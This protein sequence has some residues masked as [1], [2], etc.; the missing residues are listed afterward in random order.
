MK[1]NDIAAKLE[2]KNATSLDTSEITAES[3]YTGDLLSDVLA[4][5]DPESIWITIQK[6]KNILGVAAAKDLA[7]IIISGGIV[8]DAELLD[9]AKKRMIPIFLSKETS[10]TLSG[11]L[12]VLLTGH[13]LQS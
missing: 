1:I 7:A 10:F 4:N 3:A 13:D 5:A 2:L 9:T 6:H 11:K 8:P 12:F